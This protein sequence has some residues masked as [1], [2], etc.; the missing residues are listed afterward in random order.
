MNNH[1]YPEPTGMAGDKR[2]SFAWLP[3]CCYSKP[4][5]IIQPAGWIWL[6]ASIQTRVSA[7][8]W[9]AFTHDNREVRLYSERTILAAFALSLL[10]ACTTL[11]AAAIPL[12][13]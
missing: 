4:G 13:R 7:G 8:C 11:G 3:V 9:L 12:F 1:P 6:Q 5:A 10:L 2:L